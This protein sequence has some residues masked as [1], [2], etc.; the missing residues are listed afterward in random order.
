MKIYFVSVLYLFTTTAK[1]FALDGVIL[2]ELY[3]ENMTNA[4]KIGAAT[5]RTLV[6]FFG[7]VEAWEKDFRACAASARGWC[8]TVYEQ[9][10]G[11]VRNILQ[12]THN[13]GVVVGAYP[14][15]VLDVYEHAYFFDYKTDK[16]A[17]IDA[18]L[19]AVDWACVEKR[20]ACLGSLM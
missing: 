9:R 7:S 8:V 4:G 14:L 3:F 18:F 10:S 11:T 12:D 15:I 1:S 2:H 17:Y 5:E 6:K 20:A 16:A 19:K 13:T